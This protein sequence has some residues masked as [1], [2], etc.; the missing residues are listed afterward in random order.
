V[1]LFDVDA[2]VLHEQE[3]VRKL[4]DARRLANRDELTGV[5]NKHAYAEAERALDAALAEQGEA[6]LAVVICD[7]NDLKRVN[8]RQGHSAGDRYIRTACRIICNVFKHSPVFRIGGDEFAV[9]CQGHDYEHIEALLAAVEAENVKNQATG[10]VQ[11]ACGMSRYQGG[12][13]VAE[14]F[15]R[16]DREMYLKKAEMKRLA[17]PVGT[18]ERG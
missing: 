15:E 17:V 11:I 6:A 8:D 4:E 12:E 9:L 3:Y 13:S 2:Q 5:K 1:G 18:V 14:V 10:G 16:A 7:L